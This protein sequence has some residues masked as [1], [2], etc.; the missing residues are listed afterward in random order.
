[1]RN[2]RYYLPDGINEIEIIQSHQKSSDCHPHIVVLVSKNSA[3][4]ISFKLPIVANAPLRATMFFGAS[5]RRYTILKRDREAVLVGLTILIPHDEAEIRTSFETLL[6]D[7][8][9]A[10]RLDPVSPTWRQ[11]LQRVADII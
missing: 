8:N 5:N 1:M 9:C 10:A 11:L 7:P 3:D 6:A 2:V 4:F